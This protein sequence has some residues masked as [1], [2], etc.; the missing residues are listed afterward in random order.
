MSVLLPAPFSPSR[1]WTSPARTSKSTRSLATTPGKRLVIPR[2][3][4]IDAGGLSSALPRMVA[5]I[6]VLRRVPPQPDT[7]VLIEPSLMPAIVSSAFAF[8]SDGREYPELYS[9]TSPP[10]DTSIVNDLAPRVPPL[11]ASIIWDS[12]T[13]QWYT[14]EATTTLGASEV[15]FDCVPNH[16]MSLTFTLTE[17]S[18]ARAPALNPST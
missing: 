16:A 14:C 12:T 13:S 18:A 7:P 8:T 5:S 1:E 6:V 9:T 4:S 3:S 15:W 11:M 17:E 2:I 10:L